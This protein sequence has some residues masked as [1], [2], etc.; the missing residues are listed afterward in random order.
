GSASDI[1]SAS[2]DQRAAETINESGVSKSIGYAI[3]GRQLDTIEGLTGLG[4]I[5]EAI[6]SLAVHLLGQPLPWRLPHAE[7]LISSW[8]LRDEALTK[9]GSPDR[10][11]GSS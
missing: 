1:G 10:L 7:R 5:W 2:D 6:E 9:V 8:I 4:P 11:S 3:I